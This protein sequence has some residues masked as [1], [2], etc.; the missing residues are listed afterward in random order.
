MQ[1]RKELL[2]MTKLKEEL[3]FMQS[4]VIKT[5]KLKNVSNEVGEKIQRIFYE[6]K[7]DLNVQQ[8]RAQVRL[9]FK[10]V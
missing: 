9:D 8:L 4:Y 2:E 1:M 5:C 7:S 6:W 3:T 10:I